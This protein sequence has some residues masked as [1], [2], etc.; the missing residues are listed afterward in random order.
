MDVNNQTDKSLKGYKVIIAILTVVLAALTFIFFTQVGKYRDANMI[1][2]DQRDTLVNR[3][4]AMMIDFD[5]LKIENDTI[6]ANLAAERFRADSLMNRMKQ[7]RSWNA[8]KIRDYEKELGTLRTIMQGYVRQIDS[9]NNLNQQLASENVQLR[10]EGSTLRLRAETAEERAQ[11]LDLRVR[12]GAVIMARDIS[13]N[14]INNKDNVVT[15][16]RQATRLRTDFVLTANELATPGPRDVYVRI[17]GPDGYVLA[18]ASNATFEYEGSPMAYS[19]SRNVDYQNSDLHVNVFFNGGGI[20]AGKYS[21]TV[22]MDG[23][24][25]GSN[26]IILR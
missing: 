20:V 12:R 2:N 15:R 22:Y 23:H 26:E 9:L 19:A 11:E 25:V 17:V 21:V 14:A 3:L 18:N 5:E 6:T 1:L 8:A 13:L 7:E 24:L 4:S 16:A 10:R